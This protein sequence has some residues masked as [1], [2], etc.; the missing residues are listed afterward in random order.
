MFSSIRRVQF[1]ISIQRIE[2]AA[3]LEIDSLPFIRGLVRL[4]VPVQVAFRGVHLVSVKA[5]SVHAV[6]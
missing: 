5:L 6:L 4:R 2:A 3:A 1:Y